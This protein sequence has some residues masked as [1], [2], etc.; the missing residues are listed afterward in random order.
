[1][2][3]KKINDSNVPRYVNF[4]AVRFLWIEDLGKD[5]CEKNGFQDERFNV[6]AEHDIYL[7][8]FPTLQQAQDYLNNLV[9]ELNGREH[10]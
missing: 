1:M 7:R 4:D 6:V 5:F 2:K 3:F 10:S 9:A 8:S